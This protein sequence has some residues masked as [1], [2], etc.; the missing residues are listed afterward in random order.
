MSGIPAHV[1][2]S[3]D[4]DRSI[5]PDPCGAMHSYC[6]TCGKRQ[7]P[8]AHDTREV[9]DWQEPIPTEGGAR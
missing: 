8:C 6:D 9:T 3:G 7:D 4:F 1:C 5:C 2:D